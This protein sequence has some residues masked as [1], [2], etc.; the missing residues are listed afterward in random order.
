[1]PGLRQTRKLIGHLCGHS[2]LKLSENSEPFNY[3]VM[4]LIEHIN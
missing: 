1:M 4:D 3:Y 2:D